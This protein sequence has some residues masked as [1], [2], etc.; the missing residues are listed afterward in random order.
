MYDRLLEILTPL[1]APCPGFSGICKDEMR[2]N[3]SI[4]NI[5]RGYCGAR[6]QIEDIKLVLVFAE[7]GDPSRGE[8]YSEGPP[9]SY[10]NQLEQ[11]ITFIGEN[12]FYKSTTYILNSCFPEFRDN[13]EEIMKHVWITESVLCSATRT[14]GPVSKSIETECAKRYLLKQYHLMRNSFWVAVGRKAE[15]RMRRAGIRVDFVI[16]HPSRPEGNKP[17]ARKSW[18]SLGNRFSE[19]NR[20]I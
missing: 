8:S 11:Y 19:A 9:L 20:G 10:I 12:S 1:Y 17:R 3:P 16:S 13:I 6:G 7:P 5:P 14:T 2:W 18:Q 15:R 4:G